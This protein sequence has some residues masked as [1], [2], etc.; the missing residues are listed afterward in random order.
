M[1]REQFWQL[2]GVSLSD[3]EAVPAV[4]RRL[5]RRSVVLRPGQRHVRA[6]ELLLAELPDAELLS[7]QTHLDALRDDARTWEL[8]GAGQ[9]ACGGLGDDGFSDLRTWLV[10]Q[11]RA[12]YERVLGEPDALVDVA[13][14]D[15]DERIDD[16]E[17]WG[18]VALELWDARRDGEMPRPAFGGDEV[19]GAL[20]TDP[21]V[22]Y[23][24]LW[25]RYGRTT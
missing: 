6:L 20:V 19:R 10:S 21:Q 23:P 22:R 2:V 3:A 18:Y 12:A 5:L 1:T 11:G 13:P 9:L 15:L 14:P 4:S 8:H 24:R 17:G 7:F 25:A 16:A